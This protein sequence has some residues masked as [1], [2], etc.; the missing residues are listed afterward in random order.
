MPSF[1][2]SGVPEYPGMCVNLLTG[3]VI[4]SGACGRRWPAGRCVPSTARPNLEVFAVVG[5][6]FNRA[7]VSV[8]LEV[9]GFVRNGVLAA[10]FVLNLGKSVGYFADL[11]GEESVATGGISDTLQNPV[12]GAL[13]AA[14]VRADGVDDGLSA[15][16]HFDCFFTGDVALIIFTIA[17]QN[18]GAAHGSRLGRLQELVAAGEIDC[19]VKCRTAAGSQ[20]MYAMSEFLG[21]VGEILRD[22]GGNVKTNHETLVV[23]RTNGLIEELDGRDR[24]STR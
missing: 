8:G 21:V 16:R 20:F 6:D 3:Y 24:K 13:R 22:F 5:H 18:D 12:A 11:E 1:F 14:H 7:V 17:K 19:V 4:R 2:G 9:C 10:Q 15:L 23:V